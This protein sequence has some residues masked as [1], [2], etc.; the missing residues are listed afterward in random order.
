MSKLLYY[1]ITQLSNP[2]LGCLIFVNGRVRGKINSVSYFLMFF[3]N[4]VS[5][6]YYQIPAKGWWMS[7][8]G[9]ESG[10][11]EGQICCVTLHIFQSC[12]TNSLLE[13][14]NSFVL[15]AGQE[16]LLSSLRIPQI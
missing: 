16:L 2:Y 4:R 3:L 8:G 5:I 14:G 7:Q 1:R 10:K 11:R 9:G 15:K 13:Y 6:T 12:Q